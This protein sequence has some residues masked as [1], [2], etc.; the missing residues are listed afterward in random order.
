MAFG[1]AMLLGVV[2]LV[3]HFQKADD[4]VEQ[5]AFKS[6]RIDL[7]EG[8]HLAVASA[9]EAEKSA[10]LAT[11]DKDSKSYADEARRA[12]AEI[13]GERGELVELLE[14]KGTQH[15]RDLLVEFSHRFA[16]LR[17]ID[18]ELLD[19][20]VKD[21]NLKAFGLAFGP[22]AEAIKAMDGALSRL[23]ARGATSPDAGNVTSLALGSLAAALR[24]QALLAPHIAEESDS[25]MDELEAAMSS[26]DR[27]VRQGLGELAALQALKGDRDLEAAAAAYT[28]FAEL[29][30]QI[31]A[32]SRE[33]TNV[34]SLAISLNQK[35]KAMLLAE[36]VLVALQQA[37]EEEPVAGMQQSRPA[38]P[39]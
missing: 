3:L 5:L 37:I 15:E 2:M 19:L 31:L 1:A 24:I 36:E 14:A 27:R 39:R 29:R 18:D 34:R 17:R 28:R 35:R 6:R 16:E 25:K 22:A 23:M 13:E 26:E 20:A 10:V 8:M 32:L 12:T 9:S 38:K 30:R 11:T 4:V 21:T 33:N 7:V